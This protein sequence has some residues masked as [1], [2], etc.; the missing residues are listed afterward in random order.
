MNYKLWW[1]VAS[2][3]ALAS[4]IVVTSFFVGGPAA[5]ALNLASVVVGFSAGWLLG[6]AMSPYTAKER[7]RF[8]QYAGIFGVFV[9]GYLVGKADKAVEMVFDPAFLVDPVHDF[10]LLAF[11]TA[12]IL[13]VIITFVFREYAL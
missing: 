12:L 2:C 9:S 7:D 13:G 3:G 1:A 4:A 10:R 6:I 5:I 8:S 11:V